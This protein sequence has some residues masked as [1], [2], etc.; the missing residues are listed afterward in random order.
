VGRFV[1]PIALAHPAAAVQVAGNTVW[2]AD[3]AGASLRRFDA[4]T[5]RPIGPPVPTRGRPIALAVAGRAL[6]VVDA[7]RRALL[8]LDAL[9]GRTAAPPVP[10]PGQPVAVAADARE[11]WVASAGRNVA[12]RI[13]AR[14]GR[15]I[16]EVGV[17]RGPSSI[18]LTPSA[19]WVISARGALTRIPR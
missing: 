13:D 3:P 11:V 9:T 1:A 5:G 15:P 17:A 8:R 16:E 10:L 2:V 14:K 6:W 18:A 7:R 4:A 19:A 12:S